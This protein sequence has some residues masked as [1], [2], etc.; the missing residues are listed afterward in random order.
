[1]AYGAGA[2]GAGYMYQICDKLTEAVVTFVNSIHFNKDE[3]KGETKR[4]QLNLTQAY[5]LLWQESKDGEVDGGMELRAGAVCAA[6]VDL[7]VLDRVEIEI[8]QKSLLGIKYENSLLKV[9]LHS[10]RL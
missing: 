6:L 3:V 5:A 8:D 10:M 9:K 1:M 4:R 2:A 7:I